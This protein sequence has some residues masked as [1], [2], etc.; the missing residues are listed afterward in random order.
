MRLPALIFPRTAPRHALLCR[1]WPL[2]EPLLVLEPAGRLHGG[3]P[4]PLTSAGLVK[5]L[6]PLA[7]P[8]AAPG[9]QAR[10][11]E[12][13]LSHWEA[14]AAQHKGS[15]Q[16]EAMKAG[17]ELPD[18][19][20]ESY[21][22]LRRGIKGQRPDPRPLLAAALQLSGDLF[23]RL[24]HLQD[25]EAAQME[26]LQAS[27]E[28]G[29]DRLAQIMGLEE[30]D[31]TPADYDEPFWHTLPP[32]DYYLAAGPHLERRLQAWAGLAHRAQP[33]PAWLATSDL[34][35]VQWLLAAANRRLLPPEQATRL[36]S[37]PASDPSPDSPLAQEVARLLLPSLEHLSD[38][39]L[40][41]VKAGLERDGVLVQMRQGLA[42]MLTSLSQRRWS[43]EL[44]QEL[45]QAARMLAE[46]LASHLAD[47]GL[48]L[49]PPRQG[50]SILALP[51]LNRE[52]VLDLLAGTGDKSLPGLAD[53][54]QGW[55]TG[56]C[57]VIA[58]W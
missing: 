32:L 10:E 1:L 3:A 58:A 27:V 2:F 9:P 53:W 47:L 29:Q 19:D 28:S 12:R 51:G 4:A 5:F 13:Q 52:Q 31:A 8:A 44:R 20:A 35:A 25:Q 26:E 16:A 56:S 34:E 40:L 23:L 48:E 7:E 46:S 30:E 42:N 33:G 17:L 38:G 49:G 55:P 22:E 43:P 18:P 50:L 57:P 41:E 11:L 37:P 24:M 45:E 21:R 6:R 15:V 36:S 14:W 54:P 39:Q